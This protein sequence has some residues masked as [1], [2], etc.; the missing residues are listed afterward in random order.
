M[1]TQG[2][3]PAYLVDPSLYGDQQAIDQQ[4]QLAQLLMTQGLQPMSGTDSV[5]GVAIRRS[6]LEGVAKL[7]ALLSGQ[8]VQGQAN[9]ANQALM[10][11]QMG[12]GL[13]AFGGGT[14]ADPTQPPGAA[15]QAPTGPQLGAALSGQPQP[16]RPALLPRIPGDATGMASYSAY[17]ADPAKYAGLIASANAPTDLDKMLTAQGIVPGTSEWV[18]AHAAAVSKANHMPLDEVKPETTALDPVSHLPVGFGVKIPQGAQPTFDPKTGRMTSVSM[19]P[20]V[21]DSVTANKTAEQAG[22]IVDTKDSNG[23]PIKITKAQFLAKTNTTSPDNLSIDLSTA[24]EMRSKLLADAQKT[25]DYS[26]VVAFDEKVRQLQAGVG[27]GMV[28]GPSTADTESQTLGAKAVTERNQ[29]IIADAGPAGQDID[30]LNKMLEVAKGGNFGP[31]ASSAAKW[32]AIIAQVPGASS[33]LDPEALQGQQ[34]SVTIMKKLTANMA[35][36]MSGSAGTGTDARLANAIDSLPN[37]TA[38]ESAIKAVVPMLIA[39][40]TARLD[41]ARIRQAAGDNSSAISAVESKWR[42]AY[43]N[44]GPLAYEFNEATKGMSPQQQATYISSHYSSDEAAQILKAR[45]QLRA[46]GVPGMGG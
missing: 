39:Q 12:A 13:S 34:S 7:A 35:G 33:I 43:A 5:G 32:K 9:L 18:A 27:G 46:L 2:I 38:P 30:T 21:A 22:D 24:P 17:I 28:A 4:R 36:R 10:Q 45:Q 1:A 25:N 19:V 6:P 42:D 26:P 11:R 20:G 31:G 40:R 41:E 15:G 8:D 3:N 44:G 23:R 37:D 14:P 16:Q 29:S